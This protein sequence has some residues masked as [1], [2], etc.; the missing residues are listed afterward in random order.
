V[1]CRGVE[2]RVDKRPNSVLLLADH[3]FH[4]VR[5]LGL[6]LRS[7]LGLELGPV[8]PGT[9]VKEEREGRDSEHRGCQQQGWLLGL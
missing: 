4:L 2:S 9:R 7:G 3:V 5:G 1:R 6:G 8:Q